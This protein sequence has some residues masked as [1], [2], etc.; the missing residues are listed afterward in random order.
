MHRSGTSALSGALGLA[1]VALPS[2]LMP[3]S[4]ANPRGYFESQRLYQLHEELLDE[5][6]TSW[7]DVSP[8]PAGFL[9]SPSAARWVERLAAAVDEEFGDARLFVLKDP[10]MCRLVP[11]WDRVLERVGARPAW[12]LIVRNPIETSASLRREHDIDERVGMLLWLDHL[13]RAERDTRG[14]PRLVLA[15][16]SLLEDWRRAFTRIERTLEV[17]FPRLSRGA[18]AE[19]D[20]FLSRQLRHQRAL[21]QDVATREDVPSWVKQV[22]AWALRADADGDVADADGVLDPIAD[23]LVDAERAFGPVVASLR[24]GRRQWR[25][26]AEALRSAFDEA[27]QEGSRRDEELS[28]LRTELGGAR[29]EIAR[30]VAE[31]GDRDGQLQRMLAWVQALVPWAAT[32]AAGGPVPREAFDQVLALLESAAPGERAAAATAGLRF[33]Y[34]AAEIAR[35][36]QVRAGLHQE[37]ERLGEA[38]AGERSQRAALEQERA[39]LAA[40][41]AEVEELD[42][43]AA[44]LRTE[45]AVATARVE[46]RERELA[47]QRQRE[48]AEQQQTAQQRA[49]AEALDTE[50]ARLRGALAEREQALHEAQ[51]EITDRLLHVERLRA[52]IEA[53]EGS[54]IW[55]LTRPARALAELARR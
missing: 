52:R 10:R 13:L 15:Y 6:A 37:L 49:R 3:A 51:A 43:R 8:P 54:R 47:E 31:L 53:I 38:L 20:A 30:L 44:L 40:R 22:H 25:Q 42:R 50:L 48:L 28:K 12:I 14:Q 34:Q 18:E 7:S 21:P 9:R 1:G 16:E 46:R 39:E 4:D 17:A 55:R 33:A 19:I 24:H 36:E 23:A 45:L 2:H 5:M 41:A 26:E 27:R 35:L 29:G 11:L 32:R